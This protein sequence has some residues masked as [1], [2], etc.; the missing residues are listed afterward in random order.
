MKPTLAN[1]I[2][3]TPRNPV[4]ERR[5]T[6]PN[7]A[8]EAGAGFSQI[9]LLTVIVVLLLLALLLTPALARTRVSDQAVQCRNNLRQLLN[10]WRMYAEDNSDK[11][12]SAWQRAGDWWP[13]GGMSW[14]GSATADGANRNNWNLETTVKNSPLWPYSGNSP[15]IWKCPGDAYSCIVTG[16]PLPRVRDVSMN[17][18]FN[19]ADA[20]A[21]GPPG[22]RVYGKIGDCL[23][24]GPAKTF[25]FL[26]ERVDSINDGEFLLSMY[27][28]PAQ[29]QQWMVV[30][31]PANY[32]DGA[33]NVSFVDGHAETHPWQDVALTTPLGHGPN[34]AAP[35]SKDAYWLMDHSTRKP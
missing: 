17:A 7:H 12:P 13:V 33:C 9:D 5:Q 6:R 14:S 21:F 30:D 18:W 8:Q 23:N 10:A 3:K 16:Q 27:G 4:S 2:M 31:L 26:D 35:N 24:P 34:I 32:H 20:A 15:G 25:V 29:P 1:T 19:G 28:Y 11:V 22:F